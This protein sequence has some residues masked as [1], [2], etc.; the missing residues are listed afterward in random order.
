MTTAADKPTITLKD[1]MAF[2]LSE[3]VQL[4]GL[5]ERTLYR[6]NK[7]GDLP[8]VKLAGRTLIRR[9]ALEAMLARH[10]AGAAA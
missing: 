10:E 6:L 4:T 5:S 7:A 8:F 2:R 9:E 3:A 1:K